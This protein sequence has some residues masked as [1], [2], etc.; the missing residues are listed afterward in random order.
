MSLKG[1]VAIVTGASRGIGKAVALTIA[2]E[3]GDVV[4]NYLDQECM[5]GSVVKEITEMGCASMKIQADVQSFVSVK[6]MVMLVKQRFG[7]IDILVNNAGIKRDCTVK[8]MSVADW[9]EV[10]E[11]DLTGI[12][13]CTHCVLE[14]MI[15]QG[16]GNI[17][18]V[19]SIIGQTGNFG[20]ANYAAAKAGVIGFT[21]SVA[22]EVA[23]KGIRVNAVAPGF[24]KTDF[25]KSIPEQ[26]KN[27]ILF[28]IPMK[29]FGD[30]FEVAKTILFLVSDDSSYLTG[31]II[32]VDGG[33]N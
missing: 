30:P 28:D 5:A 10:I 25:I 4:I 16:F 24:I 2:K 3:G 8:N 20:Q 7:K 6:K 19:A 26:M 18:N 22:K 17:V 31:S 11:S 32:N 9:H 14:I 13:N 1:K 21:R 33:Y 15:K 29:R 12:F 27:Q 23:N